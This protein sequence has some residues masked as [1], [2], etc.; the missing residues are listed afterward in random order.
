MAVKKKY[1]IPETPE[2]YYDRILNINLRGMRVDSF[3]T[4]RSVYVKKKKLNKL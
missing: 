4:T 3:Q 1:R 2:Q